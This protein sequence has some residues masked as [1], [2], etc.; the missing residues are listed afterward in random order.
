MPLTYELIVKDTKRLWCHFLSLVSADRES[1]R[2]SVSLRKK[3][4]R[5]TRARKKIQEE[6]PGILAILKLIFSLS[7]DSKVSVAQL[8]I[9]LDVLRH[10]KHAIMSH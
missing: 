2:G 9:I 8:Q 4:R 1:K 10:L 6:K 5:S 3:R 7:V